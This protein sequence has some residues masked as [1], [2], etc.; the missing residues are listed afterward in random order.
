MHIFTC[1]PITT[2]TTYEIAS[3][4]LK[5]RDNVLVKNVKDRDHFGDLE[6]DGR[7][8]LKL[9]LRETGGG[10]VGGGGEDVD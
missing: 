2:H 1:T 8:M 5:H 6:M 3:M 10:G 7:I 4:N 9:D